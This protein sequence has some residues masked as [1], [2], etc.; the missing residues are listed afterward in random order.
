MLNVK[1]RN[2]PAR[3]IRPQDLTL[4]A[5]NMEALK[6]I[7]L[8][9]GKELIEGHTG[10]EHP[11]LFYVRVF[12]SYIEHYVVRILFGVYLNYTC[13]KML[14]LSIDFAVNTMFLFPCPQGRCTMGCL[15][16]KS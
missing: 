10:V 7:C 5:E 4:E 14:F 13:I 9:N 3:V 16:N 8:V 2:I 1:K 11:T 15:G 6:L 12:K